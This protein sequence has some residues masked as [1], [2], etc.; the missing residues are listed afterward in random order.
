LD[1]VLD[2]PRYFDEL[3]AGL[4]ARAKDDLYQYG[5]SLVDFV[6]NAISPPEEVQRRI[7]ERSGME[8][9]GGM[10]RYF[11]FKAAQAIGDLARGAGGEG[12]AGDTVGGTAAAGL[13]L[14]AGAGLGF[15]IP[16]MIQQAMQGGAQPKVRCPNCRSDIPFGSRFCPSCGYNLSAT[17][18]CPQCGAPAP[19][20][21]KF[22]M[23]CGFQL[24]G[25]PPAAGGGAPEGQGPQ[26]GGGGTPPAAP[27]GPQGGP[28][29]A[30]GTTRGPGQPPLP[31]QPSEPRGM[32]P[33]GRPDEAQDA[34]RSTEEGP[35][36]TAETSGQDES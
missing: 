25:E 16:G 24:G 22:C 12:G 11:Q 3:G 33:E 8:A 7:D 20:G 23:N 10:D 29:P 36:R 28:P 4:K 6:V 17:V 32:T 34:R 35:A 2:L 31:V 1:S 27:G 9:V 18:N 21:S 14:G 5:I 26:P 15:M 19:A 13:G 30:P